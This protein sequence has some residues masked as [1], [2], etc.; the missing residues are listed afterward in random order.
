MT[1]TAIVFSC[2][3]FA[4]ALIL[5]PLRLI[6]A[7]CCSFVGLLVLSFAHTAEGYP[8]L[9]INNSL[10]IGWLCMTVVVTVATIMQTAAIRDSRKGMGYLTIGALA[11][12]AVGLLGFTITPQVNYLYGIM[13]AMT[14]LG[15]FFG[16][17]LFTNTPAGKQAGVASGNFFRYLLAKGFPTAITVM[18]LGVVLVLIIALNNYNMAAK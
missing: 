15:T 7:P 14:A 6:A 4:A 2:I 8:L 17:L 3:F 18:Q 16:F 9:P 11:G 5:L 10:I 13:I 12:M 1:V